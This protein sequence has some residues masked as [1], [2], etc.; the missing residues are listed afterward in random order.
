MA[1]RKFSLIS[2]ANKAEVD[3][4]LLLDFEIIVQEVRLRYID[5][6]GDLKVDESES[7]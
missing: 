4:S 3:P 7:T 1:E 6:P 2:L 5:C